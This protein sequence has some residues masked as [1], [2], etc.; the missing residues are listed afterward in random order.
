MFTVKKFAKLVDN[1]EQDMY[2]DDDY[3]DVMRMNG[4]LSLSEAL[5]AFEKSCREN[6]KELREAAKSE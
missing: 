2:N 5:E 1:E 4:V 3:D 6:L